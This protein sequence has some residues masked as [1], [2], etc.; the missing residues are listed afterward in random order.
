[1]ATKTEQ[2][3]DHLEECTETLKEEGNLVQRARDT[4]QVIIAGALIALVDD[5]LR[6]RKK[7][8]RH[9]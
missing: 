3:L 1:M 6:R 9:G 7:E 5:V 2:L 8:A 4:V